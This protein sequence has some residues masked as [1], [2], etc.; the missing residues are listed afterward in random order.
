MCRALVTDF[1]EKN[2]KNLNKKLDIMRL[3]AMVH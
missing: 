2:V 1:S 3:I